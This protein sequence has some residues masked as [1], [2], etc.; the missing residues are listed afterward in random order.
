MS[1][2]KTIHILG[3]KMLQIHNNNINIVPF[4]LII[5]ISQYLATRAVADSYY[6]STA[7]FG[8]VGDG[9]TNDTKSIQRAIDKA[10]EEGGGIVVDAADEIKSEHIKMTSGN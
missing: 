4:L 10:A 1:T 8:A 3:E 7:D 6:Y 5:V 9:I 2:K